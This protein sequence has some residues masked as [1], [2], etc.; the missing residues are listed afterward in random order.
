M[1]PRDGAPWL[2]AE[3]GTAAMEIPESSVEEAAALPFLFFKGLEFRTLN[4]S[5]PRPR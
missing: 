4:P 2:V 3:G 5:T 1:T